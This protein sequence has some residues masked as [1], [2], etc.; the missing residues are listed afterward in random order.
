[1]A[2][3]T[4]ARLIIAC[5]V[6]TIGSDNLLTSKSKSALANIEIVYG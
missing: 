1:L 5:M 6:L 4:R 3:V 2:P